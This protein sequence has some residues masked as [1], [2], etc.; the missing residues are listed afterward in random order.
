MKIIETKVPDITK[1]NINENKEFIADNIIQNIY[2][3]FDEVYTSKVQHSISLK[4]EYKKNKSEMKSEKDTMEQLMTEYQKEKKISVILERIEKLVK[5]GLVYDSSIKH[6]I[7]ILLKILD[8]LSIDKLD[9]Q[10][11]NTMQILNKRFSR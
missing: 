1:D 8:K 4:K 2:P 11:S 10:L 7:V 5:A 3:L 9:Q 6:E